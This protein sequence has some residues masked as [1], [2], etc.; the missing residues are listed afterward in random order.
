MRKKHM[1]LR[2]IFT[3]L[4]VLLVASCVNEVQLPIRQVKARLVVDG[5]ITD[6][7]PPYPI[8]LTLSGAYSSGGGFPE[9]LIINGAVVTIRDNGDRTVQLEQ[10]PLLPSYYWV[11]DTTFRG[12]AGHWYTLKVVMPDGTVYVSTSELLAPVAPLE[13]V[14]AEFH[15]SDGSLGQ[16]DLYNILIDTR[17]PATLGDYYRW[18]TYSYVPRWTSYDPQHPPPVGVGGVCNT[19]SCWVPYYSQL[20]NVLSDALI[21]GNRISH[22]SVFNSPVYAVGK[23]YVEVRQYSLTRLA[24]QYWTRFEEQRSRTG[25]LFDPQP[26]S[27]EGNVHQQADTTVLA[28]GYFGASS[29]SRQRLVIRGDTIQYDKF[30]NRLNKVFIPPGHCPDNFSIFQL[31]PP[32]GW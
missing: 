16:P 4:S 18:S 23:Q 22:R 27:I 25:S 19:C 29:V 24:Y 12:Q 2:S 21:N 17:D 7:A 28:L 8:K 32:V 9:E 14:S 11:R 15:Q 13:Q 10:D 1:N 20:T 6:E 26:A 3:F 30:L 31:G 5:L